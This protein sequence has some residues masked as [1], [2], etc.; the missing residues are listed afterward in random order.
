VKWLPVTSLLVVLA[1][2]VVSGVQVARQAHDVR[3]LHA[4]LQ[5]VQ[6]RQD[7]LMSEY[8]RLLLERS[9]L[10]AY[11]NIERVAVTELAMTFPEQV[12]RIA[13]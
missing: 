12:E 1:A 13:P 2:A 10:S 8:T 5:D 9:A 3:E 7:E 6:H 11:Q 4:A